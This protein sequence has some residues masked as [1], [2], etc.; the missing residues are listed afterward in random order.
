MPFDQ[1]PQPGKP[2]TLTTKTASRTKNLRHSRGQHGQKTDTA[3]TLTYRGRINRQM[4]AKTL[5]AGTLWRL[6]LLL[7][8]CCCGQVSSG[9]HAGLLA[10]TAA[11]PPD[12]GP[13]N[14]LG[15]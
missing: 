5:P 9:A 4:V 1:P 3:H 10:K 2:T 11:S 7:S 13:Q 14:K 12:R 6:P 8:S 15:V